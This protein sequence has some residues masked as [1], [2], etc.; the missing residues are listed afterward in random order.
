M[1]RRVFV[2][3][4]DRKLVPLNEASYD[5]EALLQELLE[6]HPDLMA[7]DQMNEEEPRRWLLLDRECGIPN[8]EHGGNWWRLD[9][10]FA[11]QEGVP[12][13]VEV[14]RGDDP[15]GRREVV[16][17]M[18]DY[19]ASL[20]AFLPIEK[21]RSRF[22]RR[23]E[24]GDQA[25]AA[26]AELQAGSEATDPYEEF[27][28]MVRRNLQARRLRLVFVADSV[29]PELRRIVEFLNEQTDPVEVLAVEIKQYVGGDL[30]TLVPRLL[31]QTASAQAKKGQSETSRKWDEAAFFEELKRRTPSGVAPARQILEWATKF[32]PE[33]YWGKGARSGSFF[34]GL[35]VDGTWQSVVAVWTYGAV[36]VQFQHMARRTPF[37]DEA[38]RRQLL[39]K[40]NSIEGVDIPSEKLD[41]RP[42]F[43]LELLADS[44]AMASF[45]RTLD[46]WFGELTAV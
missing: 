17:Q 42:S 13:L 2:L 31:G 9:H 21:L 5:Y 30:K 4:S 6:E 16:G 8:E 15:R 3:G 20:V 43:Q 39:D 14:K 41:K 25:V 23:F 34:P 24:D 12:T 35:T 45:L 22:E 18:L 1:P 29:S 36:E 10:L 46:W 28:M 40:L 38:L 11:D 19:A 32:M 7:G 26:V 44:A 33:I 27:W 37:E